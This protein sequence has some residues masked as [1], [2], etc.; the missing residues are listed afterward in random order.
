ML[1]TLEL[2]LQ[3]GHKTL[4]AD[5]N[6]HCQRGEFWCL[7][8]PNGSGKTTFLHTLAGLHKP[9]R[10]EI[11]LNNQSL[12]KISNKERAQQ[13]GILL[14][15]SESSLTNTVFETALVARYPHQQGWQSSA[16]DQQKV[17]QAL[18]NMDLKNYASRKISSLSGGEQQRL[19]IAMVMAQ[20]PIIYLLDEPTNHLD[21]NY[22]IKTL[23]LFKKQAQKENKLI[24]AALH[25][26]NLAY[27]FAS[28]ACLFFENGKIE[29]G[30]LNEIFTIKNLSSL[31]N[32][33]IEKIESGSKAVWL[34][35]P[36][37]Y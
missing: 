31:Y 4:C 25:D 19:H 12:R 2:T 17:V 1:E 11:F 27:Q 8:G 28:H 18:T 20:D 3:L 33:T 36:D 7:I 35:N 10:G 6:L 26:I 30:R 16:D 22:Q 14:Q 9:T 5:L 23:S 29:S 24:I 37:N 13:I 15:D 32:Q 34:C 21:L